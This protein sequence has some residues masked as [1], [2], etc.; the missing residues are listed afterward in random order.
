MK[1]RKAGILHL[2]KAAHSGD[3]G[4][5][6]GNALLHCLSRSCALH[7]TSITPYPAIQEEYGALCR[8]FGGYRVVLSPFTG[9]FGAI[10]FRG[11]GNGGK[12]V[13]GYIIDKQGYIES[14]AS[15]PDD[16]GYVTLPLTPASHALYASVPLKGGKPVWDS[17]TV[18]FLSYAAHMLPLSGKAY[19]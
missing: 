6:R 1:Q 18:E 3:N 16:D 5:S 10:R 17:I 11:K 14:V 19:C 7:V 2:Q 12:V 13:C 9:H 4:N 15:I 8:G